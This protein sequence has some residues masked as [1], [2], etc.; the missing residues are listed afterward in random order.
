MLLGST[1]PCHAIVMRQASHA[2]AA[3]AQ[4]GRPPDW[5]CSQSQMPF[6]RPPTVPQ[7]AQQQGGQQQLPASFPLSAQTSFLGQL[8]HQQQQQMMARQAE[9]VLRQQQPGQVARPVRVSASAMGSAALLAAAAA[10]GSRVPAVQQPWL[11]CTIASASLPGHCSDCSLACL[12]GACHALLPLWPL[13]DSL[14]RPYAAP[15]PGDASIALTGCVQRPCCGRI[16]PT[17]HRRVAL[18]W[19]SASP[20][21]PAR[22]LH[23]AFPISPSCSR[24]VWPPRSTPGQLLC[25]ELPPAAA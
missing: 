14:S 11:R 10:A 4:A 12:P 15:E 5:R 17:L 21:R 1:R 23:P 13:E 2:C 16:T 6:A 8:H 25:R 3:P 19:T 22:R 20:S 7:P 24:C 18:P 9:Q